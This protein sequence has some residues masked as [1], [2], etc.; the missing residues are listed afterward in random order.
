MDEVMLEDVRAIL[1]IP[2]NTVK[3]VINATTYENDELHEYSK[4]IDMD[5]VRRAIKDAEM[6]YFEDDDRF[7]LTESGRALLANETEWE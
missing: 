2:K 5:D 3:L 1:Y 4:K 6:N 7:V